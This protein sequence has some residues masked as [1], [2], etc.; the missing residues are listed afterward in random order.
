MSMFFLAGIL[1][2]LIF[3]SCG[4]KGVRSIV[5]TALSLLIMLAAIF[6]IYRGLPP[7]AVTLGACALITGAI[8]YYQNEHGTMARTAFC[9][10]MLVLVIMIPL[11]FL[12]ARQAGAYGFNPEEYEITD[13]NGYT[14]NVD[15]NML[16]IQISVMFIALLGTSIDSAVAVIS[17]TGELRT[18]NP[19]MGWEPLLRS[20]KNVGKSI[21]ATSIHTIFYVYIAEYMTLIIQYLTDYPLR[22]VLNSQSLAGELISVSVSGIGCCLTVPVSAVL[23]VFFLKREAADP[24][25]NGRHV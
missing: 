23:S 11:V 20:S 13:S 14:R 6:L 2:L 16:Q 9:S 15:L 22:Y 10:V 18:A 1:I 3:L 24:E 12:L 25:K 4:D 21:L 8:L 7:A 19:S 17:S 5:S